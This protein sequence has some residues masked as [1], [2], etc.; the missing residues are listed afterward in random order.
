MIRRLLERGSMEWNR[1]S[2]RVRRCDHRFRFRRSGCGRRRRQ[3]V[4]AVIRKSWPVEAAWPP[5][6]ASGADHHGARL[7]PC[8][9]RSMPRGWLWMA[10]SGCALGGQVRVAQ[11]HHRRGRPAGRL[12]HRSPSRSVVPLKPFRPVGRRPRQQSLKAGLQ[13][14]PAFP[15]ANDECGHSGDRDRP[16]Q[17]LHGSA[18]RKSVMNAS[19]HSHGRAR[20]AYFD[21]VPGQQSRSRPRFTSSQSSVDQSTTTALLSSSLQ[22]IRSSRIV[23]E[24]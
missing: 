13:S 7:F 6:S 19:M 22:W 2:S 14:V 16:C 11:R 5:S 17:K 18:A 8:A 15:P 10:R 1:A 9:S 24:D 4:C 21:G 20:P 23:F 3:T 12:S